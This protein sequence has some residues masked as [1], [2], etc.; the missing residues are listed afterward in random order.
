MEALQAAKA[1]EIPNL[2]KTLTS[3]QIDILMKFIYRGMASADL[4][5][6]ALMLIWHEKVK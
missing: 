2:I 1:S 3:N 6:A 5:N 4:Y